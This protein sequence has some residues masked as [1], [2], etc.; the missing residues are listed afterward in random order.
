MSEPFEVDRQTEIIRKQ[1]ENDMKG[2][3]SECDA[4]PCEEASRV[5]CAMCQDLPVWYFDRNSEFTNKGE[6]NE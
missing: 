6:N 3:W 2:K 1:I 4:C 5:N